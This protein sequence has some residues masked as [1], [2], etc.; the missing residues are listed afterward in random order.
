MRRPRPDR[1]L[2]RAV[3]DLARLHPDDAEAVLGALDPDEKARVD[4]LIA[5]H[6]GRPPAPA[7]QAQPEAAPVWTYDGVSPWLLLRI[8][9]NARVGRA[10][11]EFVLMTDA[12]RDALR[13]AAEPFRAEAAGAGRGQSLLD[14]LFQK[15]AGA[16]A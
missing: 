2:K 7:P 15:L 16:R 3:A 11:R 14:R 8:D 10:G 5:D 13:E 9:P 1:A 6:E 12:A 4:A